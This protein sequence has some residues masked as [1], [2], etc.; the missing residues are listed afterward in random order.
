MKHIQILSRRYALAG[1]VALIA[2]TSPALA[3]FDLFESE[4][5]ETSTTS[6]PQENQPDNSEIKEAV[7]IASYGNID[8]FIDIPLPLLAGKDFYLPDGQILEANERVTQSKLHDGTFDLRVNDY[9]NYFELQNTNYRCWAAVSSMMLNCDAGSALYCQDD[10]VEMFAPDKINEEDEALGY[11]EILMALNPDSAEFIR[12]ERLMTRR[13]ILIHSATQGFGIEHGIALYQEFVGDFMS[14]DEM[15][16]TLKDGD[17]LVAG[18]YFDGAPSLNTTMDSSETIDNTEVAMTELQE[19]ETVSASTPSSPTIAT[20]APGD[21]GYGYGHVV[22]IT[23]VRYGEVDQ[24]IYDDFG[25]DVMEVLDMTMDFFKG[26]E[27]HRL[28]SRYAIHTIYYIDPSLEHTAQSPM[29][30][31]GEEFIDRVE[32]LTSKHHSK[33]MVDRLVKR[34]MHAQ[35]AETQAANKQQQNDNALGSLINSL[36]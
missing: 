22:L 7:N 25:D 13:A 3:F 1:L 20:P 34:S 5:K 16:I 12:N 4:E 2:T 31:S 17:A 21:A 8:D 27:N 14:T 32:F 23:G 28:D 10:L 11:R 18:M 19:S 36:F 29:S 26:E 9:G 15:L 6:N 35:A 33:R 30:M 24:E